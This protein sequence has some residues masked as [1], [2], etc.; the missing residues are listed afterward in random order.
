MKER[1]AGKK[2]SII[3][4]HEQNVLTWASMVQCVLPFFFFFFTFF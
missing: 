3:N 4:Q 2:E 1:K